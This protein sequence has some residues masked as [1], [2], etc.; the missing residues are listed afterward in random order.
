M[1]QIPQSSIVSPVF[2]RLTGNRDQDNSLKLERE[3]ESLKELIICTE[4][5]VKYIIEHR[6]S[7]GNYLAD[8]SGTLAIYSLK[9]SPLNFLPEASLKIISN[10]PQLFHT[11]PMKARVN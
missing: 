10:T 9:F 3:F 5:T 1:I 11:K 7:R 8:N 2:V 6:I 4:C